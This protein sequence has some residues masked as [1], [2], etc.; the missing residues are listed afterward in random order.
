M[1]SSAAG[2]CEACSTA[3][4]VASKVSSARSQRISFSWESAN[5]G[6]REGGNRRMQLVTGSGQTQ[7]VSRS[8]PLQS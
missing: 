2:G 8:K 1:V 4:R 5:T 6:S 3:A 7:V